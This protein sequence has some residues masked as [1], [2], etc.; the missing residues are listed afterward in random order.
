MD[1]KLSIIIG[2]VIVNLG[3]AGTVSALDSNGCLAWQSPGKVA[4]NT[5]YLISLSGKID[6]QK[7]K[8]YDA[9]KYSAEKLAYLIHTDRTVAKAVLESGRSKLAKD[10]KGRID[11]SN[12][13]FSG[14]DLS[15]L[16][17]NNV[18]LEEAQLDGANLRYANLKGASLEK[19]SLNGADLK[20]ADLSS[21]KLMKTSMKYVNLAYAK[22][23][24]A[25]LV[26]VDLTGANMC[27]ADLSAAMFKNSVMTNAYVKKATV[28]M[29]LGPPAA[30][31]TYPEA[32]F[33]YG[34]RVPGN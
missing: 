18:N 3:F 28:D 6:K 25:Q 24:G 13:D 16:N 29:I 1:I 10:D 27:M 2:L 19:A 5:K 15:S 9:T 14:A 32:V 17:L 12:A 34:L 21:T 33:E 8:N 11:L 20:S 4:K 23:N 22:M 31:Y 7:L 26:S 30:F